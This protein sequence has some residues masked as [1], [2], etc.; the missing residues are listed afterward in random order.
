MKQIIEAEPDNADALNYLGYTYADL[1]ENLDE[2]ED[3]IKRAL[4]LMPDEGYIIDSLGWVYYKK[5]MY[6]EAKEEIERA[7]EISP[8]DPMLNE[9]LG[10]IQYRLGN[11]AEALDLYH[12]AW[13]LKPEEH[14][15]KDYQIESLKKKIELLEK[16]QN[17]DDLL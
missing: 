11:Q 14:Y 5:E 1:G 12:R 9:H 15:Y 2:A 8:E 16:N 3:L 4:E 6:P 10:D 7:L 17:I 13:D